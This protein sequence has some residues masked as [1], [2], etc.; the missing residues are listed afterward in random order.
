MGDFG[1]LTT[2]RTATLKV[3]SPPGLLTAPVPVVPSLYY[4]LRFSAGSSSTLAMQHTSLNGNAHPL[5]SSD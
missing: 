5:R 3:Q 2:D 1:Y 4:V